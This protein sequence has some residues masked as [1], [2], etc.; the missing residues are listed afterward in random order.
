MI[1]CHINRAFILQVLAHQISTGVVVN[2][3]LLR[4]VAVLHTTFG[5][6][7]Q[8]NEPPSNNIFV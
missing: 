4:P 2:V 1:K 5:H 6:S 8:V 7:I 3:K